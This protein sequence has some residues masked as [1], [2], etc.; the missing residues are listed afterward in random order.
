GKI[1]KVTSL[2]AGRV[3]LQ[4]TVRYANRGDHVLLNNLTLAGQFRSPV[5]Q[6]NLPPARGS[7]RAL[8]G[9]YLLSS[10]TLEARNVQ[11]GVLGGKIAGNLTITHLSDRPAARMAA[12]LHDV[13][14]EALSTAV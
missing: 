8:S 5:L 13:S 2:P 9:D 10:G 12:Q 7:V 11:A 3:N 6:V 1:L 4:G 14:V